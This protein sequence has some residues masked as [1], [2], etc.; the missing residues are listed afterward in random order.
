MQPRTGL[1]AGILSLAKISFDRIGVFYRKNHGSITENR[2]QVRQELMKALFRRKR[3]AQ[4]GSV[5]LPEGLLSL[6]HMPE[7]LTWLK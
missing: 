2:R 5:F 4:P 1:P 7:L 3:Q 6:D